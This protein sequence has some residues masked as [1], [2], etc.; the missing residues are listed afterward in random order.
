M[1]TAP[2]KPGTNS[3]PSF[4]QSRLFLPSTC[5]AP[6]VYSPHIMWLHINSHAC[7]RIPQRQGPGLFICISNIFPVPG[8]EMARSVINKSKCLL[9]KLSKWARKIRCLNLGQQRNWKIPVI[10]SHPILHLLIWL[11]R[12]LNESK[13][14][15]EIKSK[16]QTT[17]Q[18]SIYQQLH[19]QHNRLLRPSGHDDR[20]YNLVGW[21]KIHSY[22]SKLLIK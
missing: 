10:F 12:L 20:A 8:T 17:D 5:K 9:N 14:F 22:K 4:G 7:L 2:R 18:L 1:K 19:I 11:K 21:Q 3:Q 6:F 16:P 13:I 15:T